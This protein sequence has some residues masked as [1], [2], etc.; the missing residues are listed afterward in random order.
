MLGA[1]RFFKDEKI[2]ISVGIV[3]KNK[4]GN[5][6]AEGDI[7]AYIHANKE[8]NLNAALREMSGAFLIGEEKMEAPPLVYGVVP[9]FPS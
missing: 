8:D 4:V 1:G 9:P 2:D 5:F 3:L 6:V 7:L